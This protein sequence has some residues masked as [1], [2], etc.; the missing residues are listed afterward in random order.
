MR[1]Q[2]T[3]HIKENLISMKDRIIRTKIQIGIRRVRE[4]KKF[5]K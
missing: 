1:D 3:K 5:N 4:R 2:E